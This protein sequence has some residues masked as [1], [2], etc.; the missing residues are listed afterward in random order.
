MAGWIAAAAITIVVQ[1]ALE[2]LWRVPGGLGAA[3]ARAGVQVAGGTEPDRLTLEYWQFTLLQLP[4]WLT[5]AVVTWAIVR[6][7]GL[8]LRT[9]LG[10]SQRWHDVPVGLVCGLAAQFLIIPLVYL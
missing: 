7:H 1:L 8:A 4:L 10:L 6:R 3:A 9:A 5:L 2:S